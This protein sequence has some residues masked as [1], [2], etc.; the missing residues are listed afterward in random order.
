MRLFPFF[1][2]LERFEG[3][4]TNEVFARPEPQGGL[5]LPPRATFRP[6]HIS[7]YFFHQ[8]YVILSLEEVT[9]MT[10]AE[11]L[12]DFVLY[13]PREELWPLEDGEFLVHELE[14]FQ[15]LDHAT[16][17]AL[18]TVETIEP[19]GAH[20]FLRVSAA[21]KSFLVPFVKAY[22]THVDAGAR[23]IRVKLPPGLDEL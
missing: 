17:D 22:V 23:Q 14:G 3:L 21:G 20:D 7:G 12:R 13:V 16:G 2:P 6:L 9:D 5:K 19:G 4:R 18:G 8:K 10:S 11:H 15:L 1:E